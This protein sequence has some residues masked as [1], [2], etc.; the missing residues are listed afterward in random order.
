MMRRRCMGFTKRWI[1]AAAVTVL[2]VATTADAE[3]G[4]DFTLG[5]GVVGAPVYEGARDYYAS[6]IPLIDLSWSTDTFSLSASLLDGLGAMYMHQQSGVIASLALNTGA[7]RESDTYYRFVVPVKHSSHTQRLLE[8][9][10]DAT[11]VLAADATLG[12]VTPVGL[13]GATAGYRP[14]NLDS[15]G[16]DDDT[17]Y[18]AFLYSLLYFA[19]VPLGNGVEVSL[20]AQF[21]LMDRSYARS[22]YAVK[23]PTP[24]L[25]AF[26]ASAGLHRAQLVTEAT[27]MLSDRVGLTLLAAEGVLL[28][29]A[30][31]SPYTERRFQTLVV[32]SSFYRFR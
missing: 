19:A 17:T 31:R 23:T 8:G 16:G 14:T 21:E 9:T 1:L 26:N 10:P 2:A 15:P 29:D 7:S 30:G 11:G 24:S 12:Y 18:H 32:L 5:A 13:V 28:G 4:W 22:W 27:G 25:E 20:A 3:E 6:P